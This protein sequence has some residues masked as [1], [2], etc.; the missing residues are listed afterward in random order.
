VHYRSGGDGKNTEGDVAI[1]MR[2]LEEMSELSKTPVKPSG[3]KEIQDLESL[4][5]EY[6]LS[7]IPLQLW[8]QILT[9]TPQQRAL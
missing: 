9:C 3:K 2:E 8:A 7:N 1:M 5:D 6:V 4:R